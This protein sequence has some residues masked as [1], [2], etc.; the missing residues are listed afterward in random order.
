[1]QAMDRTRDGFF[2]DAYLADD[3]SLRVLCLGKK[4][5]HHW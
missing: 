1:M 3:A 5:G 4:S 2:I